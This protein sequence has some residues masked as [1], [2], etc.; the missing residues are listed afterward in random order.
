MEAIYNAAGQIK[1]EE[2]ENYPGDDLSSDDDSPHTVI[3]LNQLNQ[4]YLNKTLDFTS[5]TQLGRL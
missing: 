3:K 5:L 2:Y 1:S 4:Q